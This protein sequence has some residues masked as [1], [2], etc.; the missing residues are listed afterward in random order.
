MCGFAIALIAALA[1]SADAPSAALIW[2]VTSSSIV[3]SAPVPSRMELI[4]LRSGPI[5][6]PILS[7]GSLTGKSAMCCPQPEWR[8]G[9][10]RPAT[11]GG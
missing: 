5:T 1:A 10:P 3:M 2:M 8:L 6:S 4:I 7:T 11:G 9:L